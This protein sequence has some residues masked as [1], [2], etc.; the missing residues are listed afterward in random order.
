MSMPSLFNDK[1]ELYAS[2]RPHYPQEL[3]LYLSGLCSSRNRA[4]D[5]ACGNGQAAESLAKIFDKV[6]ATDISKQ[7]IL[8]A[9][10]I[11]NVEFSVSPAESTGFSERS[12]DLVCVAQALHWFNLENFW[13][14]VQRVLKPDGVFSAWGYT[15]PSISPNL[16]SLFEEKIL[17]V[18]EPYWAPQNKLL[19]NHYKDVD[20]PFAKINSPEFTMAVNWNLDEF[21]DFV[22]TFSATRRCLEEHGSDFFK[23]ALKTMALQWGEAEQKK[24]VHLD[25]VLYV[26]KLN[27]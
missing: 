22:H 15:W 19:W 3:F 23:H 14:E 5:C 13:P 4:W 17:T 7:Q 11:E 24:T 16:D 20:F 2:A 26:G 25:F 8:S 10:N 1:T 12:F 21:F 6:I 18:I 9:K 27:A